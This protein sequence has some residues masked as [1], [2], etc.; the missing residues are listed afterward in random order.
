MNDIETLVVATSDIV[1]RLCKYASDV[2]SGL[3]LK[4][5]LTSPPLHPQISAPSL[6]SLLDD[7]KDLI[8][9]WQEIADFRDAMVQECEAITC[10]IRQIFAIVFSKADGSS[11]PER[12]LLAGAEHCLDAMK[13]LEVNA[14]LA[15]VFFR[16]MG[17]DAG[18]RLLIAVAELMAVIWELFTLLHSVVFDS[19]FNQEK[20]AVSPGA[21]DEGNVDAPYSKARKIALKVFSVRKVPNTKRPAPIGDAA[22]SA[23][24]NVEA[25]TSQQLQSH[26]PLHLKSFNKSGA[27][28]VRAMDNLLNV[29]LSTEKIL[30]VRRTHQPAETPHHPRDIPNL[31]VLVE[32]SIHTQSGVPDKVQTSRP[33]RPSPLATEVTDTQ[34][35]DRGADK[36]KEPAAD[37]VAD[38]AET[39]ANAGGPSLS[40]APQ[41]SAPTM[42]RQGP[43]R[44]RTQSVSWQTASAMA[45]DENMPKGRGRSRTFTFPMYSSRPLSGSMSNISGSLARGATNTLQET[46]FQTRS[47]QDI[48][49]ANRL[50]FLSQEANIYGS[51]ATLGNRLRGSSMTLADDPRRTSMPPPY[52]GKKNISPYQLY[53]HLKSSRS[54]YK[55]ANFGDLKAQTSQPPAMYSLNNA[56]ASAPPTLGTY[57]SMGRLMSSPMPPAAPS[58]MLVD[59]AAPPMSME[60]QI[61]SYAWPD[62]RTSR[63]YPKVASALLKTEWEPNLVVSKKLMGSG[64][65]QGSS[66]WKKCTIKLQPA[67]HTLTAYAAPKLDKKDIVLPARDPELLGAPQ[68][69]RFNLRNAIVEKATNVPKHRAFR[70]RLMNGI[71]ALIEVGSDTA[72]DDWMQAVWWVIAA[73]PQSGS[74]VNVVG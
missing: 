31:R 15:A 29:M 12:E 67:S 25:M 8:P 46:Q 1:C 18:E 36:G 34:A 37:N 28:M 4:R 13:M 7:D 32:R 45:D 58:A 24:G 63:P 59:P 39:H 35:V 22:P 61:A 27:A 20:L 2:K 44:H 73:A 70:I 21:V 43:A 62:Y 52:E 47:N 68:I 9:T 3:S 66:S 23:E 53:S 42:S 64:A 16:S 33:V 6:G 65:K 19:A 55:S 49:S 40:P 38:P 50:A 10:M 26:L 51:T 17:T 54:M 11:F 48:S 57:P 5:I 60:A 72:V 14:L 69:C 71:S 56:Y 30:F 74:M 41:D